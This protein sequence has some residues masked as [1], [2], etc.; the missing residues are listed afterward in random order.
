M[1]YHV[2][3]SKRARQ[4]LGSLYRSI[5]AE[6]SPAAARWFNGL[7]DFILRLETAPRMGMVTHEDASVRQ[8]VYG[9]KPH[10]YRVLY[11]VNDYE[12]LVRI[13]RIRHGK[14][15]PPSPGTVREME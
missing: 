12:H 2:E 10:F 8:L 1:T 7:E 6:Q 9:K 11:E 3:F 14:R 13:L 5:N 4:D 15:L